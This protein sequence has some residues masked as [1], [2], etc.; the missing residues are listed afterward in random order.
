M[1]AIT[2]RLAAA[3]AAVGLLALAA[4]PSHAANPAA[5]QAKAKQV[6]HFCHGN[7]GLSTQPEAPNLAGQPA[8]YLEAQLKAYRSGAR[9]HEVMSIIAQNLSD[10]DIDNLVAW[11]SNIKI[12][13]TVP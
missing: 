7:D 9:Q 12:T 10:E 8:Q 4:A 13:A 6:C 3:I 1:N 11:Y 5:G 2:H